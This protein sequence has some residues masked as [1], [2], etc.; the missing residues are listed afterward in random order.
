[1]IRCLN[2]HKHLTASI[3]TLILFSLAA[4]PFSAYSEPKI[5]PI[6]ILTGDTL[7]KPGSAL[8]LK[9]LALKSDSQLPVDEMQ[10][11]AVEVHAKSRQGQGKI[12]LRVGNSYTQYQA[13]A[14]KEKGFEDSNAESF[15][16]IKFRS[17]EEGI[18]KL[19]Q[20][21]VNGYIKV[22]KIILYTTGTPLTAGGSV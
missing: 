4:Y 2:I 9:A 6:E 10:L 1:M 13:V 17:P 21:Q 7:L 3:F 5:T 8:K 15:S 19:W 12:R 22:R 16:T 18:K 14:G 11:L 20:L